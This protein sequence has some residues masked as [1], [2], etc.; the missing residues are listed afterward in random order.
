MKSTLKITGTVA[1]NRARTMSGSV[2]MPRDQL[3]RESIRHQVATEPYVFMSKEAT[4]SEAER[5]ANSLEKKP[6]DVRKAI[7]NRRQFVNKKIAE[8]L[9]KFEVVDPRSPVINQIAEIA[10]TIAINVVH[11][12]ET[13]RK[14]ICDQIMAKPPHQQ[15]A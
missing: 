6:F 5:L 13:H 4:W 15:T 1:K 8:A 7:Y 2:L 12:L 10:Q 11:F 14:M 9:V 3:L